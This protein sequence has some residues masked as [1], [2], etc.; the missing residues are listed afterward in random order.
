MERLDVAVTDVKAAQFK[1][2]DIAGKMQALLGDASFAQHSLAT[3]QPLGAACLVSARHATIPV[4]VGV[5]SGI[6]TIDTLAFIYLPKKIRRSKSA[7]L[8]VPRQ[9]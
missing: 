3:D 1:T 4:R 8:S 9:K 5:Y 6:P 2:D 7:P